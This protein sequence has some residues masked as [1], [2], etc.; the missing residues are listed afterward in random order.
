MNDVTSLQ[1]SQPEPT[2]GEEKISLI[3]ILQ[4][5]KSY[6]SVVLCQVI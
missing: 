6:A 1:D 3:S 5:Y 2:P 4:C